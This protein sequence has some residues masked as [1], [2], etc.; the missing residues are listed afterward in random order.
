MPYHS[1]P[2]GF[3]CEAWI[4]GG[5][6]PYHLAYLIINSRIGHQPS[7]PILEKYVKPLV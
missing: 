4:W 5:G 2:I 3:L 7:R 6:L 1:K